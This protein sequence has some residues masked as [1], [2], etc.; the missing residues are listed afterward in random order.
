[1]SVQDEIEKSIKLLE[2]D[3]S[4]VREFKGVSPVYP[5]NTED[6]ANLFS[7]YRDF[8]KGKKVL[9]VTGSGD[10]LLDLIA[11]G[12][13]DIT[14]FDSNVLAKR[15]AEL[16]L[17]FWKSH[18]GKDLFKK[19]FIG[20]HYGDEI[21]QY[22]IF[23]ELRNYLSPE[24]LYYFESLYDYMKKKGIK[25]TNAD[26]TIL[27]Q[28]YD[29]FIHFPV[30]NSTVGNF[31][32]YLGNNQRDLENALVDTEDLHVQFLD[33]DIMDLSESIDEYFFI[34]LSNIF[35]F[36]SS[37]MPQ[38]RLRIRLERF[39]NYVVNEIKPHLSDDGILVLGYL[40]GSK[41]ICDDVYRDKTKYD[42]IF[43]EDEGFLIDD[44]YGCKG[45][46]IITSSEKVLAQR[47][48]DMYDFF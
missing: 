20:E 27:Y 30:Q 28:Q 13:K 19:F 46:A 22:D 40:Q 41:N 17:A 33:K 25:M 21:L 32:S 7:C 48:R 35:E 24:T 8:I 37:F 6:S 31:N 42:Y 9:T 39:K 47:K 10:A 45:K 12:S 3:Y 26:S 14:C 18:L 38:K 15:I 36:T 23:K 29:N 16:K 4:G 34:Y 2:H 5:F 1:M 43:N 11:R 44:L